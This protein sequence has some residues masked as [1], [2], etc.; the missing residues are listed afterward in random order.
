MC[1]CLTRPPLAQERG[2]LARPVTL[3]VLP[4][5]PIVNTCRHNVMN[6]V[7]QLAGK[8]D[9]SHTGCTGLIVSRGNCVGPQHGSALA[10]VL[11]LI[12]KMMSSTG[13]GQ[14]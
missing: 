10:E 4:G 14:Y 12:D 5:D 11:V 13:A 1:T 2:L 6:I 9:G 3:N 8:M 7:D